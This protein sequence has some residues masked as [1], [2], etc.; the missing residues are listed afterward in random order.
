MAMLIPLL[1]ALSS[2]TQDDKAPNESFVYSKASMVNGTIC[3]LKPP[4]YEPVDLATGGDPALSADRR[5]IVFSLNET[6][7][8]G[9]VDIYVMN[10]DGSGRHRLTS[11]PAP[12]SDPDFSPDGKRI[13][14]T[15]WIKDQPA[16]FAMD[17]D[18]A[19]VTRL[20]PGPGRNP[21]FSPDG[22]RIAYWAPDGLRLM[23]ADGAN[24]RILADAREGADPWRVSSAWS[25]DGGRI[26]FNRGPHL[27]VVDV[28][29]RGLR[30][31]AEDCEQIL[32][33]SEGGRSITFASTQPVPVHC[34]DCREFLYS[35]EKIHLC[36]IS[37]EG[38]ERRTLREQIHEL[39]PQTCE[40][41]C[42][43][44]RSR[45]LE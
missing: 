38:K 29:G 39:N 1:L 13:L 8:S 31:L 32:G 11:D 26:A 45:G 20:S 37:S 9:N 12:E 3:I 43:K 16:I 42:R 18:G 41:Q 21:R 33:W 17:S 30:A 15:R 6:G 23:D 24:S 34:D 2:F 40:H 44:P 4:E 36:R 19:N 35:W 14:F 10:A 27:E 7:L 5:R 25:P 22:R 28:E